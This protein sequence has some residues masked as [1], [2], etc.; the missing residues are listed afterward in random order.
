MNMRLREQEYHSLRRHSD[1]LDA[2]SSEEMYRPADI[3]G[4][5]VYECGG[6]IALGVTERLAFRPRASRDCN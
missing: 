6:L 4:V 3:E 5:H 2:L 1:T